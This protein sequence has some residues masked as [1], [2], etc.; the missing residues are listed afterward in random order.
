MRLELRE[1]GPVGLNELIRSYECT[2]THLRDL[3]A[4][5]DRGLR[6]TANGGRQPA[7]I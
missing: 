7:Q 6:R 4:S 3:C 2:R 1:A 5:W